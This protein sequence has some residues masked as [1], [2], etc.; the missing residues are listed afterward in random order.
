MTL[1]LSGSTG[2]SLI[3]ATAAPFLVG[4]VCFF[5]MSTAPNGFL[6]ANGG[7]VSRTT[8][9]SLFAAMGTLY[10]AG[11][12]STTFNL[13]DLR[14]EFP[15][16]LDDGR[17]VDTGRAIG[18]VQSSQNAAHR[19]NTAVDGL[20]GTSATYQAQVGLTTYSSA[21]GGYESMYARGVADTTEANASTS[22]TSGGAEARPR[23]VALLACIKF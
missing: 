7:L 5:A 12:G 8:Y 6:K 14:G 17:G 20:P 23:N 15:R 1:K 4:Q 10:G 9:A 18:S 16:G 3:E 19:H 21:T 13:P 2:A 22:S 11:D